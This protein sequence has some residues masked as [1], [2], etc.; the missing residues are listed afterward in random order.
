MSLFPLYI[1][2][3][4][5]LTTFLTIYLFYK[6]AGTSGITILIITAW[7]L[8]QGI[9]S[10]SGYYTK[11]ETVPP[12]YVFLVLPPL[13]V[14]ILLFLTK[15]GKRYLEKMDLKTLTL[16]HTVRVP[17]EFI[18]YGLFIYKGI[19]QLMTFEGRNFDILAGLTAPAIYYFGYIKN[20][21]SPGFLLTWNY[22]CLGLL[23]N[24]VIHAILSVPFPFQQFGFDQP[25]VAV[26]YFPYTWLPA[27]IVPLVLFSH[28]I[29]I[30]FL[31]KTI[32][33]MRI[34]KQILKQG[35]R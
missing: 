13:L 7:L 5:V 33:Q 1:D 34:E 10:L 35:N 31:L 30:K 12:R 21:L 9:V 15:S 32:K 25:N 20:K 16:L 3:V 17:V 4:F 11:T 14:I 26:L 29:T 2:I 24:I 19:P 18:L 27:V 8:L 28:L 6:A 22:I 23:L